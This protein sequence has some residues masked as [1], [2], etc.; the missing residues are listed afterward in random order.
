MK[1]KV[2]KMV[3]VPLLKVKPGVQYC[4]RI[5]GPMHEG[6]KIQDQK[7]PAILMAVQELPSNKPHEIIVGKLM[8]DALNDN[9]PNAGYVGKCFAFQIDKD[10]NNPDRR[11]NLLTQLDEIEPSEAETTAPKDDKAPVKAAK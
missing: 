3:T 5:V 8:R 11:Y 9:Y 6:K 1:Y 4:V 7:E 2:K 10:P